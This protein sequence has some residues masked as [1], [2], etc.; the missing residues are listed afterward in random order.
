MAWDEPDH[1]RP[2]YVGKAGRFGKKPGVLSA[3]LANLASDRGKFARWGD[4]NAYH[5]GDLSQA[6]FGWSAYKAPGQKYERWAEVLFADREPLRLREPT[7]LMLIPWHEGQVG[8]GGV[9]CTL[10]EA[11]AQ[12]I[13]LAIEEFEDVVLNVQGESWWA[14]AAAPAKVPPAGEWAPRRPFEL[15]ATPD[16]L[17]RASS[18]LAREDVVG[19]DVETTL[20]SQQLR[21]IQLSTRERTLI[22]DPLALPSLEPLRCV[23]E[24]TGPIKVI[25]NAPFERRILGETGFDVAAVADTLRLSRQAGPSKL[26][27]RLAAVCERH[28]GRVLNKAAQ[29][30]NWSARPLSPAQLAY[31]AIDAEVLLDLHDVLK[32][33]GEQTKPLFG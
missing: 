17:A 15:L 5:I 25:H 11:K 20:Y 8:P 4:G 2:V 33:R 24:V 3:N 23:L 28:L 18:D 19:L 10:E 1:L 7:F 22:I 27:H 9:S 21:L 6:L 32:G 13:E 31:A 30:S 29:T 16:A 14:P 26:S 12:V